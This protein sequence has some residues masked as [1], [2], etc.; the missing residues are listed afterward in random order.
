MSLVITDKTAGE[1]VLTIDNSGQMAFG[2]GTPVNMLTLDGYGIIDDEGKLVYGAGTQTGNPT[3]GAGN[4]GL[5]QIV[6]ITTIAGRIPNVQLDTQYP[7]NQYF[8]DFQDPGDP[9]AGG[10]ESVSPI[11][12]ECVHMPNPSA[13]QFTIQ[14]KNSGDGYVNDPSSDY[15]DPT[16]NTATYLY[17]WI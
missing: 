4:C 6:T 17:R 16:L 8:I 3:S 7:A 12:G 13:G 11:Y 5:G 14:N 2:D 1:V 9:S 10:S 15:Y